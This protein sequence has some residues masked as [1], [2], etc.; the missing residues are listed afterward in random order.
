MH[1]VAIYAKFAPF[2]IARLHAAGEEGRRRGDRLTAVEL[3]GREAAYEWTPT[4]PTSAFEWT[5]LFPG[6]DYAAL[7]AQELRA[8]LWNTLDQIRADVV[9]VPGWGTSEARATLAWC[10][11][12]DV[13]RVLVSDSQPEDRP[14]T[15]LR[16]WVKRRL[17][18]R[19]QAGFVG[20][21]PHV[22]FLARLGLPVDRCFSGCTV[23]DNEWFAQAGVRSA[24]SS[25][26]KMAFHMLSCTRLIP[27]K[28][29]LA[30]LETMSREPKDW[31]WSIAGHGPLR[32]RIEH[33]I[34]RLGLEN[35]VK[36]LGH[37]PYGKLPALYLAADAYLQPSVSEPWGLAVN[38]AMASALPVIVSN[39]CGCREDLVREGVNGFLFD[40][41][42]PDGLTKALARLRSVRDRWADMGQASRSLISD[43]GPELYGRNFWRSCLAASEAPHSQASDRI[44]AYLLA[45]AT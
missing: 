34:A 2:H 43:W 6:D 16:L 26:G 17:I 40:P 31:T 10:L 32:S 29:L 33:Q 35:R 15:A 13:P 12:N 11:R 4:T 1:A 20:G 44:A 23:A 36:L 24:G 5:C 37:V 8:R 3:A 27:Q 30:T 45:L 39:R 19:F 22:R 7:D 42:D 14:Q 18:R 21:I 41:S 9:M 38:E 28:N 25:V